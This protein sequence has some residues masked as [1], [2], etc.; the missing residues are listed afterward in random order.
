M[1]L[2][3][4]LVKDTCNDFKIDQ[5]VMAVIPTKHAVPI[6]PLFTSSTKGIQQ[7]IGEKDDDENTF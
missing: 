4:E 2:Y 7:S 1:H 3:V 6:N 5:E